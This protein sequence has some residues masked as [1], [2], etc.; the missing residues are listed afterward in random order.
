MVVDS[1]PEGDTLIVLVDFN[2][3]TGTDRD[4]YESCV[5]P[6]GSGSRDQSSLMLLD[7]SKCRRHSNSWILVPEAGLAPLDFISDRA[8][9]NIDLVIVGGR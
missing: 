2:T 3:N 8:R 6:H 9:K 4:D 1:F 7:S 5:C